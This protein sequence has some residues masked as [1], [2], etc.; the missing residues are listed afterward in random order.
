MF[1]PSK[2]PR[3]TLCW[4]RPGPQRC[5]PKHPVARAILRKAATMGVSGNEPDRFEYTP[6][7]GVVATRAGVEIIAGNRLL[8]TG[9]GIELPKSSRSEANS[10][11]FVARDGR[12]VGTLIIADTLRPEATKAVQDLHSMGMKTVLLTGDT[13]AV[14]DE[15]GRRLGVDEV[16]AELLP[17]DKLEYVS[18][19]TK[20]G[21]NV[22][23]VGDGVNDAPALMKANVG[24]AMGTGTDVAQES[25]NVILIGNDLSKLVE[26]LSIARRCRRTIMQ[27]FVGTLVVDTVG[28]GLAA[29]GFLNPLLAAFIHVS[30]ELAFILNSARLLPPL[31]S[32]NRRLKGFYTR[33]SEAA[34]A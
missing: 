30:S 28:V 16:A 24:I 31:I 15:I 2:E 14:A 34:K 29:F 20:A 27:N 6:G 11:V 17:E 4:K 21:Q 25:A 32:R 19:L 7:K 23:M 18:R 5:A 13:K 22:V 33:R 26:T 10:E 8:L 1:T 3:E 9:H 12:F